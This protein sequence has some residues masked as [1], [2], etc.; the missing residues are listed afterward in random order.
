VYNLR[1][2]ARAIAVLDLV[3]LSA[4]SATTKNAANPYPGSRSTTILFSVII[5][6]V[7]DRHGKGEDAALQSRRPPWPSACF[8]IPPR[9]SKLSDG[10]GLGG[11]SPTLLE[12]QG[13]GAWRCYSETLHLAQAWWRGCVATCWLL[14]GPSIILIGLGET[15]QTPPSDAEKCVSDPLITANWPIF[16]KISEHIRRD[17]KKRLVLRA[18]A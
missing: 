13:G 1:S 18:Y 17:F 7:F 4:S 10:D 2:Y 16:W 8:R 15:C 14:G 11:S 5:L 12:L 9:Q 6:H 3:L